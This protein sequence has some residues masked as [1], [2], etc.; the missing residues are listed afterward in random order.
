MGKAKNL[1]TLGSDTY[2]V[3]IDR[4]TLA[5]T[6]SPLPGPTGLGPKSTAKQSGLVDLV[7]IPLGVNKGLTTPTQNFFIGL[8][9]KPREDL[10]Q[11]DQ[12][13]TNKTLVAMMQTKSVG[14][15]RVTGLKPAVESLCEVM[16]EIKRVQPG[17]YLKLGLAGMLCCRLQRGSKTEIS[18]HAWGTA[19]D[20]KI[21]GKLDARDD[22]KV[23]YGLTLIAPIFNRNGW[24]WGAT[25]R[26][27]DAMHF[28][29]S[30]EKLKQW[31]AKRVLGKTAGKV[32]RRGDSGPAVRR[33]QE[34]LQKNGAQ[35]TPDGNFGSNTEKALKEFQRKK[36]LKDDGIAGPMTLKA[37][38]MEE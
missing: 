25:F 31:Q 6:R 38:G 3:I 28:E 18:S 30:K 22:N 20:L 37:L 35:L 33:L 23:Q 26:T 2:S 14:P 8:L 17:L 12:P 36:G 19:I 21:D 13:V 24:V 27:E 32:I 16:A 15:F 5:L 29:V 10:D 34:Q 11:K 7:T 1:G 9:G 4:G